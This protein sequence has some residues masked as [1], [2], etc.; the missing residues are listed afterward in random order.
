MYIYIYIY[1]NVLNLGQWP[2]GAKISVRGFRSH[3][4]LLRLSRLK[5]TQKHAKTREYTPC[6]LAKTQICLFATLWLRK[7]RKCRKH[8]KTRKNTCKYITWLRKGF[9]MWITFAGFAAQNQANTREYAPCGLAKGQYAYLQLF[10]FEN[11]E[12]KQIPKN[13]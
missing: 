1:S 3:L 4:R 6:G 11:V 7:Q 5:N 8:I 9:K 12:N 13:T 10:G 2:L